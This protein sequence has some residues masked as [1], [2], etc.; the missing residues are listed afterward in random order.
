MKKI[1]FLTL[2]ASAALLFLQFK[3][4]TMKT[5][6]DFQAKTID[7]KPFSFSSLKGK[8]V[9][10]VNTASECGYTPQYAEL[11]ELY[12]KYQG[13]NFVIIGF[14]ANNF[15]GQE[16]GSNAEIKDF[17][18]KNYGVSFQMMEKISVDG[19]DA[20]PLYQW[21]GQKSANGVLDGKVKWNFHKFL[22]DANGKPVKSLPSGT[23]PLSKEIVDWINEK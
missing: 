18:K 6:Y 14:P 20:H 15:G 9:M 23:K 11:E 2:I 8:K 5:L 19:K 4:G 7:G 10:I 3:P 22:I 16:P 1:L 17:C 13:K 21:L 12:K